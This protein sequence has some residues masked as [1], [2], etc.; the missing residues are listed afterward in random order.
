MGAAGLEARQQI[1]AV[2][3]QLAR[4]RNEL[5][6]T[7]QFSARLCGLFPLCLPGMVT[8]LTSTSGIAHRSPFPLHAKRVQLGVK[9]HYRR[10]V[11]NTVHRRRRQD[12]QSADLGYRWAGAGGTNTDSRCCSQLHDPDCALSNLPRSV[13]STAGQE[14]YRAITS[15]YYRGAV[16]ALLVYDIA[17]HQTYV[18][19]TRWL[20]ELR[21]HADS[22]IVSVPSI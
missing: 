18:N 4:C 14:R 9:V 11:R 22:N 10:R 7:D 15:A 12:H 17:K 8:P 16:G 13:R 6:R 21:D 2:E 5:E 3:Q 1:R 20:K 19:V